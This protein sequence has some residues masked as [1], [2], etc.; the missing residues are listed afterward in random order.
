LPPPGSSLV[1]LRGSL[2]SSLLRL[3]ATDHEVVEGSFLNLPGAFM[4][5][6]HRV[7]G[8]ER[9][10]GDGAEHTG[11]LPDLGRLLQ[12]TAGVR[13]VEEQ[14]AESSGSGKLSSTKDCP[15]AGCAS[16]TYGNTSTSTVAWRRASSR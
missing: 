13:V 8:V 10:G 15:Y 16:A 4:P 5:M 6:R 2:A 1:D 14:I 3:T 7:I 12:E 11:V 9:L